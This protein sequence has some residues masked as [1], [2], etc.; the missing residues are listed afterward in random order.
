MKSFVLD[1]RTAIHHFPGIGR[2]I[3]NLTR[4][5]IP[6]LRSPEKLVLLCNPSEPAHWD[7]R[8]L[9]GPQVEMIDIA[10]S[11][12]SLQQQWQIPALL[13]K[14]N[15]AM[16]HSPYYLMP[17]WVGVPTLVTIHDLIPMRYPHYFA[18]V[19]RLIFSVAIRLA[20]R[21]S[22][23]IIAVSQATSNDL[24]QLL[25]VP[26][27]RINVIFEA[28]DSGFKPTSSIRIT[29]LRDRLNLPEQYVLYLG[30][31]KPH[32]NLVRLVE[33]WAQMQPPSY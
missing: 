8:R 20:V 33:A 23:R 30:S 13:K 15:A 1:A 24:E 10:V 9:A 28:A 11:P 27:N 17:Y 25:K 14:L 4:A 7:L 19:Q 22:Q 6:Q 3:F 18:R 21:R 29:A 2:Y 26:K 16:Y 12:F 31:N 5:M 32:K